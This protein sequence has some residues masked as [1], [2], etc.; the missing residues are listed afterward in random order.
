ML[1]DRRLVEINK[2]LTMG[3]ANITQD[4]FY[5]GSR[6]KTDENLLQKVQGMIGEGMDILDLGA[7]STR[8]GADEVPIEKEAELLCRAIE[9]VKDRFGEIT[10]SADTFRAEVAREAVSSG[11]SIINDIGGGNLDD[12]M[13]ETV[14]ELGVPYIL[15][16]SRGTPKTMKELS[17]YGDVVNDVVFEL[18]EKISRLRKLGV[19]DI[20]VDPGFGFAKTISQNFEMLRRLGEFKIL[21]CPILVGISRKSMI[22][23]TLGTDPEGSLN[24]TSVLNAL[25]LKEG[26]DV[27]RVHDIKQAREAIELYAKVN[28]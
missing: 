23:K 14:A 4:S 5:A 26:A 21:N 8:P 15:M 17:Q 1:L 11:A 18:G 10:I 27:L 24:G 20:I 22:W 9:M 16:H 6:H 13:F 2:P 3:I 12:K 7:Y 19:K 28:S 25:A